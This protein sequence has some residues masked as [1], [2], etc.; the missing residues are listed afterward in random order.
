MLYEVITN[1][2]G[3]SGMF[4][5]SATF[6]EIEVGKVVLAAGI[7]TVVIS[8]GWNYYQIDYVRFTPDQPYAS[9]LPI[10]PLPVNSSASDAT[11]WLYAYLLV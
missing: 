9:A 1:G 10:H 3:F 6:A 4:P 2:L 7:N 11:R 8:G 5:L